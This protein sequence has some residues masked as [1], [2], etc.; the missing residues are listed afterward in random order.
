MAMEIKE[1][2]RTVFTTFQV[3]SPSVWDLLT[4]NIELD[5]VKQENVGKNTI[6]NGDMLDIIDIKSTSIDSL[7]D[8]NVT[9]FWTLQDTMRA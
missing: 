5:S 1:F 7:I 9:I 3:R 6:Y 4:T 8:A 2:R